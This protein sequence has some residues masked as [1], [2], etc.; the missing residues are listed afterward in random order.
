MSS[1]VGLT[2]TVTVVTWEPEGLVTTDSHCEPETTC[3]VVAAMELVPAAVTVRGAGR[4]S[5]PFC[6]E[7]ASK[8]A[9]SA[10]GIVPRVVLISA[11]NGA[12]AE[13]TGWL[14]RTQ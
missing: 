7:I 13:Q 11:G 1:C 8:S 5:L 14:G 12:I 4:A 2:D 9:E 6:Q 10:G 3:A